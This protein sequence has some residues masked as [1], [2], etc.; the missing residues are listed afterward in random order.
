[1][2]DVT[3]AASPIV[4]LLRSVSTATSIAHEI[5]PG[6]DAAHG[7]PSRVTWVPRV[8]RIEPLRLQPRDGRACAQRRIRFDVVMVAP[9]W[10]ALRALEDGVVVALDARG[11]LAVAYGDGEYAISATLCSL[12]REVEVIEPIYAERFTV[13][14]PS[15]AGTKSQVTS[16]TGEDPEIVHEEPAP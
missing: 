9:D 12:R 7:E 5:G 10:E 2:T 16:P 11:P 1:M 3:F 8:S 13:V 15:T 6:V 4:E 14:A